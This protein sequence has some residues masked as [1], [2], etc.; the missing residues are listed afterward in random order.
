MLLYVSIS[1]VRKEG[2][3]KEKVSESRSKKE[4]LLQDIAPLLI[5]GEFNVTFPAICQR[6]GGW[7]AELAKRTSEAACSAGEVGVGVD[8]A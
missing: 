7:A 2:G 4:N 3:K 6:F 8:R 5:R 1:N